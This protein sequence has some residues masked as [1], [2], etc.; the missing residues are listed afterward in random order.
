M[1]GVLAALG[2]GF[3]AVALL[4]G[5]DSTGP[6]PTQPPNVLLISVD[7]LRPD[8]LGLH[9]FEGETSPFIDSLGAGGV[10]FENA[11]STAAWTSPAHASLFSGLFPTHHGVRSFARGVPR[12]Y[13]TLASLLKEQGYATA[14]VFNLR[15]LRALKRGFDWFWVEPHAQDEGAVADV[16]ADRGLGWLASAPRPWFLFL[17]FYDVH[18]DYR[19]APR[20]AR[21]FVEPYDGPATGDTLQLRA[22]RLGELELGP[23]DVRHLRNLYRAGIRQFDDDLRGV[24]SRLEEP[25]HLEDTLV[26]LTSDHGEEFFDHGSVLHGRTLHQELVRVP[27]IFHGPGIPAGV[28]VEEPVSLVDLLPTLLSLVGAPLPPGID[29]VDVSGLWKKGGPTGRVL[30]SEAD[31]WIDNKSGNFRRALRRGSWT[32]HYDADT[33]SFALYDLRRDPTEQRNVAAQ[34][35][36]L[37]AELRAE[38]RPYI[39]R[40]RPEPQPEPPE[41]LVEALRGLGYVEDEEPGGR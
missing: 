10:V 24:F 28:R 9:G 5:C 30:V 33:E 2:S 14:A 25:G 12:R 16:V 6:A 13:G 36:E 38:L 39:P 27:L 11:T 32:L 7:T 21:R 37:V 23:G 29:G 31:H 3:V 26:V 20:Y 19:P 22:F 15:A 1:P 34:H 40:T 41:D 4:A 17:H 18:S 8:D 35:P